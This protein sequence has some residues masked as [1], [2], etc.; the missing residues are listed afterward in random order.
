MTR[1]REGH[2]DRRQQPRAPAGGIRARLRAGYRLLILDMSS[3]G[4][5]VEGR[6]PLPPGS[7]VDVQIE[8]NGRRDIVTARVVRCA[9]SAIDAESGVTYRAALSFIKACDWVREV[10]TQGGYGLHGDRAGE[11]PQAGHDGHRLPET[12]GDGA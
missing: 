8:A 2:G 1:P 11:A 12:P 7:H 4:A 10:L 9:V 5:L 6:R 3:G